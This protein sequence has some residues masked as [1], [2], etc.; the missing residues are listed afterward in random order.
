MQLLPF[1]HK[2]KVDVMNAVIFLIAVVVLAPVAYLFWKNSPKEYQCPH[3]KSNY[4][5][6]RVVEACIEFCDWRADHPALRQ[7]AP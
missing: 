7:A 1:T 5:D 2:A 3:C 4:T 6:P